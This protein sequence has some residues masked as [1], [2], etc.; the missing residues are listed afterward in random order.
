MTHLLLNFKG[1]SFWTGFLFGLAITSFV[2]AFFG[3]EKE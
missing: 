2:A 3:R 1:E